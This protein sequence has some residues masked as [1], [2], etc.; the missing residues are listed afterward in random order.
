[1]PAS[2]L[3]FLV[4]IVIMNFCLSFVRPCNRA[5]ACLSS[6]GSSVRPSVRLS[7]RPAARSSDRPSVCQS[8]RP[9]ARLSVRPTVR[10]SVHPSLRSSV[11]SSIR[12]PVRPSVRS[13]VHPSVHSSVSQSVSHYSATLPCRTLL[14]CSMRSSPVDA[15]DAGC[16]TEFCS[17]SVRVSSQS[18]DVSYFLALL[19]IATARGLLVG[20]REKLN[21]ASCLLLTPPYLTPDI[22]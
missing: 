20:M 3:G 11:C 16:S 14:L 2:M 19:I 8:V 4:L 1:M 5:F 13:S 17:S 21:R 6:A 12:P 22:A 18:L 10:S 7:V 9:S 15:V